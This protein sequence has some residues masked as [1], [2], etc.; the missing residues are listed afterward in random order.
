[1]SGAHLMSPSKPKQAQARIEKLEGEIAAC[2][3]AIDLMM[4]VVPP[5]DDTK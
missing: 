1:M 3:K 4:E 2:R 5:K